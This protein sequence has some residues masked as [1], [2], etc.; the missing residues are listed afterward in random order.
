MS[1]VQVVANLRLSTWR[2]IRRFVDLC[3]SIIVRNA[4]PSRRGAPNEFGVGGRHA[5]LRIER[6][7]HGSSFL[8]T[9]FRPVQGRPIWSCGPAVDYLLFGIN[10]RSTEAIAP[11]FLSSRTRRNPKLAGGLPTLQPPPLASRTKSVT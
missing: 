1:F 11:M 9:N 2:R 7:S 6:R 10:C 5:N 8:L 4:E 3:G